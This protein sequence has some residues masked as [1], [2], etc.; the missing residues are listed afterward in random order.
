MPEAQSFLI[1]DLINDVK[2]GYIKIPQF[3]RDFIWP[4]E[5]AANLMDSILKSYPIG[6]IILWKTKEALRSVRNLGGVSLPETPSGD[7]I[8]YVLDGQQRLTSIFASLIGAK[9]K[10]EYKIDDFSDIYIN[11][12]ASKDEEIVVA[13]KDG[14]D[15]KSSIKLTSLLY[16]GLPYLG[17]FSTKYQEK[18]E[19]YKRNIETYPIPSVL[20]R[21]VPI[22]VATEIFTRINEG[23]KP[24][25]V[26]EIM[27]AKTFDVG[28]DFDLAERY[29]DLMR[30]LE[31]ESYETISDATVLRTV[32][33]ILTKECSKK[34]ILNIAKFDFIDIWPKVVNAIKGAVNYLIH[35]FK[36]PVSKLLPYD[37]LIVLFA[38][39][40]YHH[41]ERP[42]DDKERYLKDLF[43]RISLTERYSSGTESKIAQDIKRVD[44]ILNDN[45][46]DYNYSPYSKITPEGIEQNG[47]FS[48][49]RS[50]I[51]ALLCVLSEQQ[52][53]SFAEGSLVRIS[54]DWLKQGNSKNYHHFFP[55]SYLKAQNIENTKINHIANITIVDDYLNKRVI[56]SKCP[57]KYIEMFKRNPMLDETMKSHLIDLGTF[58]VLND[59]YET[60]FSQRIKAISDVLKSKIIKQPIDE[61]EELLS[62][63]T[64]EEINA[65]IAKQKKMKEKEQASS[66]KLDEIV[67]EDQVVAEVPT[68]QPEPAV[69]SDLIS[70]ALNK[71]SGKYFIY[72]ESYGDSNDEMINPIG[73]IIPFDTDLFE[74]PEEK[75]LEDLIS[76]SLINDEQIKEYKKQKELKRYRDD[77]QQQKMSPPRGQNVV[78]D[79]TQTGKKIRTKTVFP[80]GC[81]VDGIHY[82]SGNEAID[83]LLLSGKIRK[84]NLPT[85]SYNAHKWLQEN[86]YKFGFTY[87]RDEN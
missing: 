60:F 25:S 44:V 81:T 17:S 36:I 26:F 70:V 27:V 64:P 58:G 16:G 77:I 55:K 82:E 24:L 49:G 15:D 69:E 62:S 19:R 10:R 39:F 37:D 43:W 41:K 61:V 54:N 79:T 66:G 3:Q 56:G 5:K 84:G 32:S 11:L 50:Y 67:D 13:S 48:V 28:R 40:F 34:T 68:E 46:P 42:L 20:I 6:T 85:S 23:G 14:L 1:T 12:E 65:I 51:K 59:D 18:I 86:Y 38:Y 80:R 33:A 76:E 8:Q 47:V 57:S 83:A 29:D 73:K 9:V 78:I 30:T 72:L 74:E 7:F 21:D 45:L 2:R 71:S 31:K 87:K 75:A 4:K 35:Y 63:L 53:K 52:P 22:D